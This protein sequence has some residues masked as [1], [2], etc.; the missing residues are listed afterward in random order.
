MIA[1]TADGRVVGAALSLPDY[2]QVFQ[3]HE[4]AACCRSA[5]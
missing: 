3:Q 2:N 4:R 5:G 1:E